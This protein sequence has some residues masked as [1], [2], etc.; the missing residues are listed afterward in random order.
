MSFGVR[1]SRNC[2]GDL[3]LRD[4]RAMKK[5]VLLL[6]GNE[7]CVAGVPNVIM[8][9][10][11]QLHEFYTF[12]VLT[13]S[14]KSGELDEKFVSYGGKIFRQEI[15]RYPQHPMACF[16]AYQKLYAKVKCILKENH[17]DIIHGHSG[18]YDGICL[19]AARHA[20]IQVRISHGHGT[21]LWVGRNFLVKYYLALG[22]LMIMKNATQRVACSDIAGET[23]FLK[24]PFINVLNAVDVSCY[25]GINKIERN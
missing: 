5:R 21:Y 23:L 16:L 2:P 13:F 25:E 8:N 19:L 18:Y 11:D 4:E 1:M 10:V 3:T 22:K 20:G 17:Y 7:L 14:N 24:L 6:V 12:D 9:I 15:P